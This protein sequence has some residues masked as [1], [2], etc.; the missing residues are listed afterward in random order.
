M[1]SSIVDG[2]SNKRPKV[3]ISPLL[4]VSFC[5]LY[6]I[7]K[8][9]VHCLDIYLL[10]VLFRKFP[11]NDTNPESNCDVNKHSNDEQNNSKYVAVLPFSKSQF[12]IKSGL[13]VF[14]DNVTDA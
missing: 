11:L 7:K 9:F 1:K 13:Y 12:R 8:G 3:K 14:N 5:K 2:T 6:S 10:C 4:S